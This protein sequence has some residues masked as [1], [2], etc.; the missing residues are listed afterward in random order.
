M[1]STLAFKC[2]TLLPLSCWGRSGLNVLLVFAPMFITRRVNHPQR[3]AMGESR[4]AFPALF[5][6]L[7]MPQNR[8]RPIDLF[9][10]E[11]SYT[12]KMKD[13][14]VRAGTMVS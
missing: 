2:A 6:P 13:S 10:R 1:L 5:C 7:S 3:E 12:R 11:T 4:R 14:S 8:W 9:E